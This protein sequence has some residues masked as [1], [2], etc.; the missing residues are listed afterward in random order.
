MNNEFENIASS[1]CLW[2]KFAA[3]ETAV[4]ISLE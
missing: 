2:Q 1:C 4:F 3:S